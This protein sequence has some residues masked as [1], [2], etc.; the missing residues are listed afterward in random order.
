MWSEGTRL[1]REDL[2]RHEGVLSGNAI[3]IEGRKCEHL[4]AGREPIGVFGEDARQLIGRYGGQPVSW[5]LQLVTGDRGS[6]DLHQ[7]L[8]RTGLRLL[9]VVQPE[10]L[11]PARRMQSDSTHGKLLSQKNLLDVHP[12]RSRLSRAMRLRIL[13][14]RLCP[15]RACARIRSTPNPK[16][17][18]G[19]EE[20]L[21]D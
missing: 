14:T 7:H 12:R 13:D 19:P 15:N 21:H 4:G 17:V 20:A 6:M 16:S 8:A 2:H 18:T 5:P 10:I 3:A 9:Y 1:G 11:D